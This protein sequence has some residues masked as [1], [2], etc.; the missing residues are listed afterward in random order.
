MTQ[1]SII[2]WISC[3]LCV[4]TSIAQINTHSEAEISVIFPKNTVESVPYEVL[5]TK[6][7]EYSGPIEILVNG[8]NKQLT[9]KNG[10][11]SLEFIAKKNYPISISAQ[12]QTFDY[13]PNPIPLWWSILPPLIAI[14]LA[15]IFREVVTS[16]FAGILFGSVALAIFAHG[17]TGIFHG[18]MRTIDTYILQSLADKSHMS[19]ILFSM[20]IG[21]TVAVISKNGGMQGI[22][23]II[24][25]RAQSARSGQFA[26]WLLG[27]VIFFDD[28]ANTLVVGNTMRPVTDRLWISREKLA[29]IVDSTAAPVAA[30]AFV[31]TWIG[32]ELGY[33]ESGISN[34]DNLNEGVYTIFLSSLKYAFYPVLALVFIL[35]LVF[36]NRDFGPMYQAEKRA[37]TTGVVS[38]TQTET[39]QDKD[40][41]SE[42]TTKKGVIAR[43]YNAAVPIS[44]IVLG[45][46]GGLVYTGWDPEVWNNPDHTFG[47]KISEIIGGSDSYLALLWSSLAG[48]IVA[49]LLSVIQRIMNITEVISSATGGFK[50]MLEAI[51]ILTL[52]WSL[53]EITAAMHTAEFLTGI[54]DGNVSPVMVPAITFLLAALISFSTGT[55]WGTM[56]ILY[57]LIL[58]AS[59]IM[60]ESA[61][62]NYSEAIMIFHNVTAC[63]LAGSVLGDHCS[64][65]SDTTILSSLAA[66]C[67]HID[68]VRTQLPY[69]LTVGG[70]G[71]LLG[72]IPAAMGISS[73]ILF[74]VA[75]LILFL[76]VR[77]FGRAVPAI[78]PNTSVLDPSDK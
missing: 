69:A 16:L 48:L 76:I 12:G 22:V 23:D 2:I 59:W 27:I 30:I 56:A 40:D 21:G 58:P 29:Y 25:A 6:G 10:S 8:E 70:V 73:W 33:I 77:F 38:S 57:P 60:A 45:T 51:I 53:A 47:I 19:I 28:Y 42:F 43:W 55:S 37:R 74:P 17:W 61:G 32:A 52:A 50:T 67:H 49:A 41:L 20:L 35:F 71:L 14:A 36:M 9:L 26:T 15:L 34:L 5:I 31:T 44:V 7:E 75:I 66:S 1:K 68:H 46:V 72:T 24:S 4:T 63:V 18:M 78:H 54:L 64:P 13:T 11:A 65:I 62:Y 3:L 39:T